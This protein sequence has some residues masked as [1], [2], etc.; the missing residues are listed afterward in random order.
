MSGRKSLACRIAYRP[1]ESPRGT[2][3][4][5]HFTPQQVKS[6][7]NGIYKLQILYNF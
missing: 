3:V 6:E 7:A 4:L 5:L 2:N 1:R